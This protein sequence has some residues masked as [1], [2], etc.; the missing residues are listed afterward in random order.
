MVFSG[1]LLWVGLFEYMPE[2]E[3]AAI[4]ASGEE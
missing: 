2:G 1:G 3:E 4:A